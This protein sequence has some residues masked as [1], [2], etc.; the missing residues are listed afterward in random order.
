M[1][2]PRSESKSDSASIERSPNE[3]AAE[4]GIERDAIDLFAWVDRWFDLLSER[5][6]KTVIRQPPHQIM[7]RLRDEALPISRFVT[8]MKLPG[9]S[10][11]CALS[12]GGA[13]YDATVTV[14]GYRDADFKIEVVGTDREE[15]GLRTK[16]LDETGWAPGHGPI[17]QVRGQ[18][19]VAEMEA[20]DGEFPNRDQAQKAIEAY[21]QK[22]AKPY[23]NDTQLLIV[24]NLCLPL[25]L[26]EW[27]SVMTTV[28]AGINGAAGPFAAVYLMNRF[29]HVTQT[30]Y[31]RP[32]LDERTQEASLTMTTSSN[33]TVPEK[34][35]PT[36]LPKPRRAWRFIKIAVVVLA[37]LAWASLPSWNAYRWPIS[38]R[39]FLAKDNWTIA[40]EGKSGEIVYPW[41]WFFPYTHSILAVDLDH[42]RPHDA[43]PGFYLAPVMSIVRDAD[44][45]E[46]LTTLF[47]CVFDTKGG[48]IADVFQGTLDGKLADQV[49]A[50]PSLPGDFMDH[51]T[52]RDG[53]GEG[54]GNVMKAIRW[55][56]STE[57]AP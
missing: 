17:K 49:A 31:Y 24:A 52:W 30:V 43:T 37:I 34:L 8:S 18:G 28:R 4:Y 29:D 41:T 36:T 15:D 45:N 11:R 32:N 3:L 42:V 25:T 7:R 35:I 57:T 16:L 21:A 5:H 53:T 26:D 48:R 23:T 14:R 12:T 9:L 1:I 38:K 33:T 22:S 27:Q 51:L 54:W 6:G 44:K 56:T 39:A 19:V 47:M 13:N 50:M 46:T 20:Y 10:V 2:D 40:D 55:R